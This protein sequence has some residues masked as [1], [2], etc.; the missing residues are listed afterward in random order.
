M[1]KGKQLLKYLIFICAA[2]SEFLP[3]FGCQAFNKVREKQVECKKVMFGEN[4]SVGSKIDV[5]MA[6]PCTG[7]FALDNIHTEE[8]YH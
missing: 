3:W 6:E 5:E 4:D 1:Q 8:F 2:L 7:I